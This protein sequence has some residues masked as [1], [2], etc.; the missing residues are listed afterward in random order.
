LRI[1]EKVNDLNVDMQF[2]HE[3]FLLF[4]DSVLALLSAGANLF[5][6]GIMVDKDSLLYQLNSATLSF[7]GLE[8]L[9]AAIEENKHTAA[10][11][12]TAQPVWQQGLQ[13]LV[14][15]IPLKK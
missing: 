4:K 6:I 1:D 15:R 2:R 14:I 13:T 11:A 8:R 5:T 12:A 10:L 3:A 9:A 7:D